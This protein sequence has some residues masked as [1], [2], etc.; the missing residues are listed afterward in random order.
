M[1]D[2]QFSE[3]NFKF[4]LQLWKSDKSEEKIFFMQNGPFYIYLFLKSHIRY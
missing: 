4:S 2:L 3:E 1:K